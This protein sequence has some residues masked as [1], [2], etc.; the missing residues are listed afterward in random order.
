MI[1]ALAQG[2]SPLGDENIGFILYMLDAVLMHIL[3]VILMHGLH[4]IIRVHVLD[5][6]LLLLLLATVVMVP[7]FWELHF[8]NDFA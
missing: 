6:L 5:V 4:V 7:L 3:D 1:F 2:A 8:C